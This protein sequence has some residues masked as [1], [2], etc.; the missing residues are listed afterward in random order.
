MSEFQR[1]N[2]SKIKKIRFKIDFLD[3]LLPEGF[4]SNSFI[5]FSGEGGISKSFI[6]RSI[7]FSF[8]KR[9]YIG[10]YLCADEHPLSAYQYILQNKNGKSYVEQGKVILVDLFSYNLNFP[11]LANNKISTNVVIISHNKKWG[12]ILSSI[13]TLVDSL[14]S[15]NPKIIII[16]DSLTEIAYSIG[17]NQALDL[18]KVLRMEI[19]KKRN[20]PIFASLHFGIRTFEEF[21]QT[22]EYI[23]DGIFDL[24]YDPILLQKGFLV[25]Q[26]RIRKI[27][28]ASHSLTWHSFI[29]SKD[30]ICAWEFE[31]K[32][33]GGLNTK[34]IK[35]I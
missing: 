20:I 27:R 17:I 32:D 5:I 35:S 13:I 23:A 12:E 34:V 14:F 1:T 21:E 15:K 2:N 16:I 30:T 33:V 28:N 26:I 18:V 8:I 22:V 10:I 11:S 6:L 19:C 3:K 7:L 31:E 29:I 25:K 24:R 9:K 4:P